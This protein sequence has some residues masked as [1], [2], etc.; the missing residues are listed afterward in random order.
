MNKILFFAFTICTA[1]TSCSRK[2]GYSLFF[3]SSSVLG[4][5][6]TE[7]QSE[8]CY[9]YYDSINFSIKRILPNLQQYSV[10]YYDTLL[11]SDDGLNITCTTVNKL[12]NRCDYFTYKIS[13]DTLTYTYVPHIEHD[14]MSKIQRKYKN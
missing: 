5:N 12:E 8:K 13:K 2:D 6:E 11:V 10:E 3:K 4:Y 9:I 1:F 7:W 14:W